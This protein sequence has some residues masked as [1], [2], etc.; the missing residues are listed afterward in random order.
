MV[1]QKY[2]QS[3]SKV[4]RLEQIGRGSSSRCTASS[5]LVVLSFSF[6]VWRYATRIPCLCDR[7]TSTDCQFPS[8]RIIARSSA[9][10]LRILFGNRGWQGGDIDVEKEGFLD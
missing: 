2:V 8:A 5:Y 7:A 9:Y 4:F 1:H 3:C 10:A 6:Q